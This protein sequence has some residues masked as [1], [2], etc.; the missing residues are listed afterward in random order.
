MMASPWNQPGLC[1][2]KS[3]WC[4]Q[5]GLATTFDQGTGLI[6]KVMSAASFIMRRKERKYAEKFK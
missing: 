4:N 2:Y 6:G 1:N 3:K 5:S